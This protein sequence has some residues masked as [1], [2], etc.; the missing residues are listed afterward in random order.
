MLS[1]ALSKGAPRTSL[2]L[3]QSSIVKISKTVSGYETYGTLEM[4]G[5]RK[6]ITIP[7]T[8]KN[9]VFTGNFNINRL[10]YKVGSADGIYAHASTNLLIELSIPVQK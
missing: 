4:H 1:F 5:V 6:Q 7:F 10:D 8:F 9:N 2:I 3:G